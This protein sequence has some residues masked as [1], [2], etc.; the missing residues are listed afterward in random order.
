MQL[1]S[2]NR[3]EYYRLVLN[4][5][6]VSYL[7]RNSLATETG[8]AVIR[9]RPIANVHFSIIIQL[10]IIHPKSTGINSS[11]TV[12]GTFLGAFF[13]YFKLKVIVGLM[14]IVCV[15]GVKILPL[16]TKIPKPM[17]TN[18]YKPKPI[19]NRVRRP[20]FKLRSINLSLIT[21]QATPLMPTC[22]G[23]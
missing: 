14:G 23:K 15:C 22:K 19:D 18:T 9:R 12:G 4:E 5:P 7:Q 17:N 21:S 3:P 8:L 1:G 16:S 6:E 20:G 10:W 2:L 11:R 13:H